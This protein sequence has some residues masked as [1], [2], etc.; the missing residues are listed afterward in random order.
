MAAVFGAGLF[1]VGCS[2]DDGSPGPVCGNGEC[3][4]GETVVTCPEDCQPTCGNGVVEGSEECDGEDLDGNDCTD[5]GY[6]GGTLACSDQCTF[7]TSAC[8]GGGVCG[9]G[10]I[11]ENEECDGDDLDGQTCADLG[12]DGGTLA[13]NDTDCMFDTSGCCDDT[14]TTADETRCASDIVQTCVESN[15]C[16]LWED[17]E[18]C[19]ASNQECMEDGGDAF[20]WAGCQ[21]ECD[22]I[23]DLQCNGDLIEECTE[24]ATGC[25]YWEIDTDCSTTNQTCEVVGTTPECVEIQTGGD[26]CADPFVVSGLPFTV[27]GSDI[28]ADFTN[29]QD[30]NNYATDCTYAN[31]AAPEVIME[32][33]MT[34]GETIWVYETG[35]LD[36]VLRVLDSCDATGATCLESDDSGSDESDGIYFTAMDTATYY[37]V[38]EAYFASESDTDYSIHIEEVPPESDCENTIDDDSDGLTDCEDPDCF[39]QTGCTTETIC[40]DGYDNDNNGDTDCADTACSGESYCE[41]TETTCDDSFDNDGDGAVDCD[42]SDCDTAPACQPMIGIWEE[43]DTTTNPFDLNGCSLTFT[44]DATNYSYTS[45]C[46]LTNFPFTPGDG[47]VEATDFSLDDTQSVELISQGGFS[48]DFYGINY[49]SMWVSSNGTIT[50][51]AGDTDSVPGADDFFDHPRIAPFYDDL[52]PRAGGTIYVDEYN[53]HVVVTYEDIE[54]YTDGSPNTFQVVLHDDGT[55]DLHY[56]DCQHTEAMVGL[57]NGGQA[58]TAPAPIDF[59]IGPPSVE[60]DLVISEF[61]YNP[62]AV[63]DADG[64][65]VE[66]FNPTSQDLNL[67]GCVIEDN[68]S[69]HTMG[70][71]IVPAGGY[72]VLARSDNPSSNG[73]INGAYAYGSDIQ[74]GNGG[75]TISITCGGELI[76]GV[77]FTSGWPGSDTAGT[78]IQLSSYALNAADNDDPAWWCDSTDTYGDGDTGTPGAANGDCGLTELFYEDFETWPPTGWTI[79]DYQTDSL[80]WEQC[81]GCIRTLDG[82]DGAYA[83]VDSDSAGAVDMEEELITP[84]IDCS[85]Y[86]VVIL[87]YYHYYNVYSTDSG[88]VEISVDGGNTWTQVISYTSDT[89]NGVLETLDISSI[90]ANESNVQIRFRYVANWDWYWL[91]DDVT[92]IGL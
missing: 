56:L 90:A 32:I 7:D 30:Y 34:A 18:D 2:D 3:E 49:T 15:G 39:G 36:T 65:Y 42:D 29:S 17:T 23:G 61:M 11:D 59:V 62:D 20:C 74:L 73:G 47:T 72:G 48:F 22:T 40:D 57:G 54:D 55:I 1:I 64:E 91:L 79:V 81:D 70:S 21:D 13:C 38:I 46:T 76:D 27:D 10:I 82:A 67:E 35:D 16:L 78:S 86:S 45:D 60:G 44:P 68:N 75:D 87:S 71:Y 58:G 9:N 12:F 63:G 25:L 43:F 88:D 41:T 69:S 37:V 80:T 89:Q 5:L 14:C 84:S 6:E 53:T 24:D 19:A 52:D 92:V 77:D 8:E 28:Y 33:D 83:M 85:S 31:P 51:G 66:I 26:I 50:F 4:Q